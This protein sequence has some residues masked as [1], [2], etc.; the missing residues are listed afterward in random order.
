ML[1]QYNFDLDEED[2]AI[3]SEAIVDSLDIAEGVLQ[4]HIEDDQTPET[5]EEFLSLVATQTERI[6]RLKELQHRIEEKLGG[7]D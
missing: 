3:L 2:L 4:C 6:A 7:T 5:V 1:T